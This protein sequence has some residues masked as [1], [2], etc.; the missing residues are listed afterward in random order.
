MHQ[1]LPAASELEAE[2]LKLLPQ[3]PERAAQMLRSVVELDPDRLTALRP[4]A[5]T[6]MR[7][8]HFEEARTCWE[9]IAELAP[10]DV[11]PRMALGRVHA[12]ADRTLEA[13]DSLGEVL[14]RNPDHSEALR[15]RAKVGR[16]EIARLSGNVDISDA[17]A[18]D[19]ALSAL[20]ERLPGDP[21]LERLK[22]YR[23][24]MTRGKA[25]PRAVREQEDTV[26]D[27]PFEED[28]TTVFLARLNAIGDNPSRKDLNEV[29][30]TGTL[31]VADHPGL[32]KTLAKFLANH[33]KLDAALEI[34]RRLPEET[35]TAE[36][37]IEAA[38]F[39]SAWKRSEAVIE[40]CTRAMRSFDADRADVA[41]AVT[42]LTGIKAYEAAGALL[43][44]LPAYKGDL[45]VRRRLV[46]VLFEAGHDAELRD[47]VLDVL[48]FCA[49]FGALR[50]AQLPSFVE[51]MRRFRRSVLR[52]RSA[53]TIAAHVSAAKAG[54]DGSALAGWVSGLI[55]GAQLDVE[56]ATAQFRKAQAQAPLPPT[57]GVDFDAEI[58]L[59]HE[60]FQRYGDAYASAEP[61]LVRG[62]LAGEYA[63]ATKRVREVVEFCGRQDGLLYPECLI[64]VIFEEIN[65]NPIGYAPREGHLLTA[66]SSLRPGGSER[67]TVTVMGSMTHD[68][69]LKRVVLAVRTLAE[70]DQASFLG[71]AREM[72][73]EIVHF[74]DN[75]LKRSDVPAQLPQLKDR[76]RLVRAIDL[77]PHTPR[78][79]MIRF[80]KLILSE[81]PQ[82][83]HLRQDLYAAA[84]ACALAGVPN[85]VIHRG[86]VSPNLWGHDQL[87]TELVLRPMRHA[88]R[89]LL[90]WPGFLIVNNSVAGAETDREW[91]AWSDPSRFRVIHN[92]VEFDKLD[93]LALSDDPRMKFGIPRNAFLIGGVFRVEA[94]KRPMLWIEAAAKVAAALDNAHFVI[95]G[96]GAM[97]GAVR[98]YAQ[99]HGFADRLHMPGFVSNVGS[100]FRTI[101]LNL[102]TSDREGLPNVLV[103]GQHFGV[104]VVSADVG[105]AFETLEVGVTGRL[106]PV[107]AGA[108]AYA[109][110]ILDIFADKVW[111]ERARQR[112][113]AFVHEKFG[114]E[115]AIVELLDSLNIQPFKGAHK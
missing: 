8:A 73:V 24:S 65:S 106:L 102:L 74:G 49:P 89:R 55:A 48:T 3:Q 83:V 82:A 18:F 56:N 97:A 112:A 15:L 92:A 53:D 111:R 107:S 69:R 96:D 36:L 52:S 31:L 54:D 39:A 68:P 62:E 79:D 110:V 105:G 14:L 109:D 20:E 81:R 26:F 113:P 1:P 34:Y 37:W 86:S 10:L 90:D 28:E 22:L 29:E 85:F 78:E 70:A 104:P 45:D 87:Q 67:Q 103:E 60:R 33:G 93:R 4:L 77:L 6:L 94:V 27:D 13:L 50:E 101:D 5:R 63:A 38:E 46:R 57:L 41:A 71:I 84:I 98:A 42:L 16:K 114:I 76:E 91:T 25:P 19:V 88:Y 7:Q 59:L 99:K 11:E 95:L 47:E 108:Q 30:R 12:R 80:T 51:I 115:R 23:A 43:R 35:S 100:W 2:A 17:A 44:G 61:A 75:W 9:R 66:S 21:H 58:A 32:A 40:F 64:D 72:A